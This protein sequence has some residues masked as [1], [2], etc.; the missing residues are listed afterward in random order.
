MCGNNRI[1]LKQNEVRGHAPRKVVENKHPVIAI[2]V[3][4]QEIL[5]QI[6]LNFFAPVFI[7]YEAFLFAHFPF[8]C[9]FKRGLIIIDKVR[10]F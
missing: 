2:L 3:L 6:L 8:M 9:N 10:K 4:F 7:K 1:G 5:K